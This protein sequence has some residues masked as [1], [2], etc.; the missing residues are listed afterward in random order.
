MTIEDT[1]TPKEILYVLSHTNGMS[2]V[3]YFATATISEE[4]QQWMLMLKEHRV[5]KIG[6]GHN[7][8]NRHYPCGQYIAAEASGGGDGLTVLRKEGDKSA[9][10]VSFG[11]FDRAVI[12]GIVPPR[13]VAP[14]I[15]RYLHQLVEEVRRVSF[16]FAVLTGHDVPELFGAPTIQLPGRGGVYLP[17]RFARQ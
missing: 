1:V 13:N 12:G 14:L 7:P 4:I 16:P 17:D 2:D 6:P 8:V 11:V 5:I 3:S 15:D 9:V 10:V